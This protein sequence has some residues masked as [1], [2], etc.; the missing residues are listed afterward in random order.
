MGPRAPRLAQVN[1]TYQFLRKK[2]RI[3]S[4]FLYDDHIKSR[5][6][7]EIRYFKDNKEELNQKV[8]RWASQIRGRARHVSALT[9]WM[10]DADAADCVV[11]SGVGPHRSTH[12]N[13]RSGSTSRC[14]SSACPR[15]A[16]P[17]W[18]SSVS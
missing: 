4:E 1:V 7:K 6:I 9:R 11:R 2:F 13:V 3:F 8:R 14:A 18:T 5:L 15:M 12:T 17:T 10:C 16:R